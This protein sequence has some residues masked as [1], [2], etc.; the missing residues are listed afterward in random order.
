MDVLA[1]TTPFLDGLGQLSGI[2]PPWVAA[3]GTEAA[4]AHLRDPRDPE[5]AADGVRPLLAL[6]PQ[7]RV[8]PRAAAGE[9]AA[10]RL[11]RAHVRADRRP[12]EGRPVGLLLR[13][14]R[15]RGRR[16]REHPR[17]RPALHRRAHGRDDLA[18]ALLPRRRHVHRH[19]GRAA[20]GRPPPPARLLGARPLPHP[21]RAR[22]RHPPARGG[23]PQD[24]EHARR[25]LRPLGPRPPA[26]GLRRRRRR[27]RLRRARRGLDGGRP[28]P[29]R[30]RRRARA[31][32]RR[33]RR[34]RRRAHRRAP[35]RHC[36]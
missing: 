1:D 7:G 18:P 16:L 27:L 24:D 31:R 25:P 30:P 8:G 22:E 36:S 11:G 20:R 17:R 9:R 28:A 5:A 34:R 3:D 2:L 13:R 15:R 10:S 19:A 23:D 29:L 6:H 21:P 12:H 26:R 32:Q 14:P 35:G 4:L 33:R